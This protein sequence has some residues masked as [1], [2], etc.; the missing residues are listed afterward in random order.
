[1]IDYEYRYAAI[2]GLEFRRKEEPESRQ[3]L[4]SMYGAPPSEPSWKQV[5]GDDFLK[6]TWREL[7]R[8]SHVIRD[9]IHSPS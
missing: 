3:G 8:I 7:E 1:M 2:R 9:A 5:S 6:M 4:N